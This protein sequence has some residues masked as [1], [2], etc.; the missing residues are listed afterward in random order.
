MM[1]FKLMLVLLRWL[2]LNWESGINRTTALIRG[3]VE[4]VTLGEISDTGVEVGHV[5][6]P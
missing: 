1:F 6:P 2:I 4:R 5:S 3:D